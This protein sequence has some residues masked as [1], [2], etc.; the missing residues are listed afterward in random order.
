M[1][2]EGSGVL[3]LRKSFLTWLYFCSAIT[4]LEGSFKNASTSAVKE[5]LFSGCAS[6]PKKSSSWCGVCYRYLPQP[7]TAHASAHTEGTDKI[8]FCFHLAMHQRRN[9]GS[10]ILANIKSCRKWYPANLFERP[11]NMASTRGAATLRFCSAFSFM[12]PVRHD[13][14]EPP[15]AKRPSASNEPGT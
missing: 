4:S 8:L 5:P 1:R 11:A 14:P 15:Q 9:C 12:T 6:K 3:N 13:Q 10:V 7:L 2:K